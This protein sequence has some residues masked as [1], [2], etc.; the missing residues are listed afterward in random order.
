MEL[1]STPCCLWRFE[2]A[3]KE[4]DPGLTQLGPIQTIFNKKLKEPPIHP[5]SQV[6]ASVLRLFFFFYQRFCR[7]NRRHTH[8]LRLSTF[9]DVCI[10]RFR[11]E[12]YGSIPAHTYQVGKTRSFLTAFQ[13]FNFQMNVEPRRTA[14]V[15]KSLPQTLL[16]QTLGQNSPKRETVIRPRVNKMTPT[17]PQQLIL[18]TSLFWGP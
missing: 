13:F 7:Q 11:R 12:K 5:N 14:S 2:A 10:T 6:P 16:L 1:F 4:S 18:P 17:P 15:G 8:C 3:R 9:W